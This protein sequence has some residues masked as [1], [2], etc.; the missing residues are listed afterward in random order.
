MKTKIKVL[1][2]GI[3]TI[4]ISFILKLDFI[5][6]SH[7]DLITVNS[8]LIGF[9]FTSLS[10]LLGFLNEKI[11]QF[12]EKAGAL[13]KVYQNI[14]DGICF[15]LLSIAVSIINLTIVEKY[16]LNKIVINFLYALEINFLII[17][18]I[19]L[20]I[21][22]NNLKIIIESIKFNKF[23]SDKQKNAEEEFN[24]LFK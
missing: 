6:D 1:I 24:E 16:V 9:L 19:L 2:I 21:T 22:I 12:F 8:V 15:S 13:R 7:F 4:I 11:I 23:K 17:T 3:I 10:I 18:L 14:E 5:K 20:F